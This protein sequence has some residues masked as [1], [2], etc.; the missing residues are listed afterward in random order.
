MNKFFVIPHLDEGCIVFDQTFNDWF[1][2]KIESVKYEFALAITRTIR[3]TSKGKPHQ[4]A[5]LKS[6]KYWSWFRQL[7]PFFTK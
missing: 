5:D 2:Q 7:S 1:H 4:E 6:L 3:Q